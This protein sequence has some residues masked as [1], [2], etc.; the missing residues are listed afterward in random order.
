MLDSISTILI[1]T[2]FSETSE[3]AIQAALGVARRYG[4]SIVLLHVYQIPIYSFPDGAFVS[5]ANLAVELSSA[6]Q[7]ALDSTLERLKKES[8]PVQGV[9]REGNADEAIISAAHE[10]KADLIVVGTH[11]RRGLVRALLGS[12]AETVIRTVDVPVLVVHPPAA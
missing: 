12:V 4:S 9:L 6:A 5:P 3:G 7:R 2:D 8:I 1:P 11:A 10:F